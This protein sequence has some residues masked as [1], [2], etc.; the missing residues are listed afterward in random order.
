MNVIGS[1]GVAAAACSSLTASGTKLVDPTA[2]DCKG[3]QCDGA[4][5]FVWALG[6]GGTGDDADYRVALDT[7]GNVI[8]AGS[9]SSTVD[10]DPGVGITSLLS[11]GLRDGFISKLS[12]AGVFMSA[13]RVG[14]PGDDYVGRM[15][16]DAANNVYT[17]GVFQ[18]TADFDPGPG[19]TNLTSAGPAG[20]YD[21]FFSKLDSAGNLAWAKRIGGAGDDYGNGIGVDASGNV[22]TGGPFTGTVDFDPGAGTYNLVSE[23]GFDIFVS[24]LD[25]AGNFVWARR[26]GGTLYDNCNDLVVDSIGNVYT[27]GRF[28]D[29]GD[30][31]P[32]PGRYGLTGQASGEAFVSALDGAGNLLWAP[33]SF[34][35]SGNDVVYGKRA[36]A[37]APVALE[38]AVT[39]LNTPSF[40][41]SKVCPSTAVATATGTRQSQSET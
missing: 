20:T 21:A 9:F 29:G 35:G 19:T 14:G 6:I 41:P 2:G 12:G 18:L 30:F 23:G 32:A 22:Y 38:L 3:L 15:V 24:K 8:S 37:A 10:F 17:A 28:Q 26:M 40:E 27:S 5:N 4:G 34:G 13:L 1:P 25:S 7:A 33:R 16:L 11:A 31:D 39:S 36:E